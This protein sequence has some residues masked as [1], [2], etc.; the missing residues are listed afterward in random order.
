MPESELWVTSVF[1]DYLPALGNFFLTLVGKTAEPRP[2]ADFIV[3]QILLVAA[4]MLLFAI[5]RPRLSVD[6]P[7]PLQH[8]VEL[9]Y[10]FIKGQAEDQVG[11]SAHKYIPFFGT[12]F[13]FILSSNLI[14]LAPC[15]E[16]PTNFPFVTAGC[17][18]ATFLYYNG[19]GFA[20]NGPK[21]LAH[22]AGPIWWLAPL[23]IPIEIVSHLA[24]LLSLTV[25]L[26]ANM[27]AGEQVTLVFINLTKLIAPVVFMGLHIFVGVVQAYIFMLLT[28]VYVGG[29]V[30]HEH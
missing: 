28:M 29:A 4:L 19:V 21:Y 7:S 22:F 5:I 6:R 12:I 18:I 25:R 2:W 16:S 11:H 14:G 17:A 9:L 26:Y 24:R 8:I 10:D 3:M 20:A 30:A 15:F 13:I 23:M 27:F 1:N